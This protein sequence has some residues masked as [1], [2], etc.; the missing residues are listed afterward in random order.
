M[1][2]RNDILLSESGQEVTESTGSTDARAAAGITN[3]PPARFCC[4]GPEPVAGCSVMEPNEA[5]KSTENSPEE[6]S[7]TEQEQ[8]DLTNQEKQEEFWREHLIQLRRLQCPSCG[9]TELF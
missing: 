5:P 2:E 9:E 7:L 6:E 8:Q 4:V 3:Y 1:E